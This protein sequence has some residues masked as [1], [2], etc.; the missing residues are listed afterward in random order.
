ML[1]IKVR[2]DL[3]RAD[4]RMAQHFLHPA[5]VSRGLQHV[6]GETVPEKMR[7][8]PFGEAC[9][10]RAFPHLKD[11]LFPPTDR[12]VA[13]LLDDLSENGLLDDTLI[14]MAGEFGRTPKIS[15][16]PQHY[17]LPG[18][19]HWGAVQ[20]VFLAGADFLPVEALGHAHD[21][22][23]NFVGPALQR[24][25]PALSLQSKLRVSAALGRHRLVK[26]GFVERV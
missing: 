5:Q 23:E 22:L 19:D 2:V 1:E 11:K 20:S 12:A 9:F 14:V 18:R 26:F 3:G 6:G 25:R 4:I 24:L 15:L 7:V 10:C 16:L 13:A 17:A 21:I 8:H